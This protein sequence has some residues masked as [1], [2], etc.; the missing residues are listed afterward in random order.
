MKKYILLIL[1][2]IVLTQCAQQTTNAPQSTSSQFEV[3][4][5]PDEIL[6]IRYDDELMREAKAAY[7]A[8]DP[9]FMELFTVYQKAAEQNYMNAEAGSVTKNIG[10]IPPSGDPRDFATLSPYWW[11]DPDTD[12][13]TPYIRNDGVRNPQIYEFPGYMLAP[14]MYNGT[15][16]LAFLYFI[17]GDEKY[18]AKAAELLRAWFLDPETGMNPNIVFAQ[19]VPGMKRIRGTGLL[20]ARLTVCAALNAATMMEKSESWTDED[21]AQMQDWAKAFLYW[22]EYSTHGQ[23][24]HKGG[25]NHAL[26]YE[27]NREVIALY[28]KDYDHL[29]DIILKYQVPHLSRQVAADS[30]MPHEVART[31]GL[32]YMSYALNA[33]TQT[34][35][36][37]RKI[38]MDDLISPVGPNG[39]S[40]QWA[41]DFTIRYWQQPDQWPFMQIKP[42]FEANIPRMLHQAYKSTGDKK[43][44][45]LAY[46]FGFEGIATYGSA[47]SIMNVLHYKYGAPKVSGN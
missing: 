2:G 13:G 40:I 18:A 15:E 26:W 32:D 20:A 22:M 3:K 42:I 45:D 23:E 29:A 41:L 35:I 44:E 31:L 36:V 37:A 47:P 33:V 17:T 46:E 19:F 39:R 34:V 28:T 11:P 7:H 16:N 9:V 14:A 6:S 1:A 4:V 43:Y 10:F 38:G 5:N 8:K 30:T 24:E 12:D 21:E 27:A 25:N